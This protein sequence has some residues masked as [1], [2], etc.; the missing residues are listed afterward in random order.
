[1]Q[2]EA[3]AVR[4]YHRWNEE[5]VAAVEP[6]NLLVFDVREGW[7]PLCQFLRLDTPAGSF[8]RCSARMRRP[9]I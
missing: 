2:Q 6:D 1:M 4:F 7:E 9:A 8:P 5:V 3:S